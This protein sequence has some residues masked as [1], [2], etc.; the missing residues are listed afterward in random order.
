ML[1]HIKKV[2]L[3][4]VIM[5]TGWIVWE[6]LD[7]Y[8]WH[9]LGR[10]D[11]DI[12]LHIYFKLCEIFISIFL[13]FVLY[14]VYA[15]FRH[16]HWPNFAVIPAVLTLSFLMGYFRV[17]ANQV[18]GYFILRDAVLFFF[19]KVML[20]NSVNFSLLFLVFSSLYFLVFEWK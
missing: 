9:R 7:F 18:L 10:Y 19:S 1:N 3:V 16:G 17:L 4:T 12:H 8:L 20:I 2:P 11:V 6:G 15:R 5:C 13:T 14:S